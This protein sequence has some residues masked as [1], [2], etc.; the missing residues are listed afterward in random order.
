MLTLLVAYCFTFIWWN[1]VGS[2]LNRHVFNGKL[3]FFVSTILGGLI[4]SL[5]ALVALF[6]IPLGGAYGLTFI[7]ITLIPPLM[8][9]RTDLA[10]KLRSELK[11]FNRSEVMYASLGVLLIA[12]FSCTPPFFIDHDS[13]YLPTM[14]WFSEY[15]IVPGIGNLH[16]RLAYLSAWQALETALQALFGYSNLFVLNGFLLSLFWVGIIRSDRMLSRK[17]V[18]LLAFPLLLLFSGM[19][20][21]DLPVILVSVLLFE[22]FTTGQ[23]NASFG[24]IASTILVL[25]KPSLV[26]LPLA[27]LIWFI[28]RVKIKHHSAMRFTLF[29]V[30]L[31]AAVFI[32]KNILA[33]GYAFFPLAL[34]ASGQEWQIPVA[35]MNM[36]N[37]YVQLELWGVKELNT[38]YSFDSLI[39]LIFK[40]GM[41]TVL[42]LLALSMLVVF[43]VVA[44]IKKLK[45]EYLW[46]YLL[47][48]FSSVLLY[49]AGPAPRFFIPFIIFFGAVIFN[50]VVDFKWI[51]RN[52]IAVTSL[53]LSAFLPLF[54][55][56]GNPLSENPFMKAKDQSAYAPV[57]F[58]REHNQTTTYTY[59][60]NQVGNLTYYHPADEDAFWL[61]LGNA[62]LPS[63]SKQEIEWIDKQFNMVPQMRTKELQDGFIYKIIE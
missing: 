61:A 27:A 1:A 3:S 29:T 44:L 39:Q 14:N 13:Y 19:P 28:S 40:G 62:P 22:R 17:H 59:S 35:I 54:L 38:I 57:L 16:Y 6:F 60:K 23:L 18:A 48:L 56:S 20:A 21:P 25:I 2:T 51:T 8:V 41:D 58:Q 49:V 26:L 24:L 43:P 53:V 55:M 47:F 5:F 52:N 63:G 12:W 7:G 46:V 34:G 32:A 15:G 42:Y 10:Q 9:S 37:T 36:H 4:L 45:R 50:E 33:T 30:V 31:A 11:R